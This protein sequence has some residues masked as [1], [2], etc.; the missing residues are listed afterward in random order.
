VLVFKTAR[1]YNSLLEQLV[2]QGLILSY[3][4]FPD[5]V[6]ARLKPKTRG[7]RGRSL[8]S[9]VSLQRSMSTKTISHQT[10]RYDVQRSGSIVQMLLQTDQGLL[11]ANE[12]IARGVGGK[13]V[14]KIG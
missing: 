5:L 9:T 6:I 13:P 10:L 11:R 4:V 7:A 2:Q 3:R 14:V 12:A 8:Q 1:S